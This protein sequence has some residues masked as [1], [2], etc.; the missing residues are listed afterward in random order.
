[1]Y[2]LKSINHIRQ[3]LSLL[4]YISRKSVAL[5]SVILE[6]RI[7][8][9]HLQTSLCGFHLLLHSKNS[10][11][12]SPYVNNYCI[13]TIQ[14]SLFGYCQMIAA[15]HFPQSHYLHRLKKQ[16]VQTTTAPTYLHCCN[17]TNSQY[18]NYRSRYHCQLLQA[19]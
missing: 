5:L 1:M 12:Q 6:A 9:I 19:F 10:Q 2:S 3:R 17:L 16:K 4:K 14:Y 8:L 15:E 11:H 7:E 18:Q 13:Y